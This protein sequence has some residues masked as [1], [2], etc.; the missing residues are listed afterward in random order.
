M[1]VRLIVEG[2]SEG[3]EAIM[4]LNGEE[5]IPIAARDAIPHA[6]T[7]DD[8]K[9]ARKERDKISNSSESGRR[10]V[11]SVR[12]YRGKVCRI[13]KKGREKRRLLKSSFIFYYIFPSRFK[14]S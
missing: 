14:E 11:F 3:D 10:S 8:K 5:S 12:R 4:L 7:W 13:L 2:G 1:S 9:D 6:R